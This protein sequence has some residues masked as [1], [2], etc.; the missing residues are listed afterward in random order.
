MIY[1]ASS[2]PRRVELL[3]QIGIEFENLRVDIDESPL[4]AEAAI[5]YVKRM[6]KTKV[7]VGAFMLVEQGENQTVLAADTI[8]AIDDKIRILNQIAAP[9][10][11]SSE[12]CASSS[13]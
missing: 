9:M 11:N 8:I 12:K 10:K 13:G 1:L 5:D 4:T 7:E 3:Q 2:S 6:A